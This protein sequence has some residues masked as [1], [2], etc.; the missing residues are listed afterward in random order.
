MARFVVHLETRQNLFDF[1][2]RHFA[3]CRRERL[4]IQLEPKKRFW[5]LY[6]SIPKNSTIEI[7][8][9][10]RI[11]SNVPFTF[12]QCSNNSFFD[13]PMASLEIKDKN[14]QILK[15]SNSTNSEISRFDKFMIKIIFLKHPDMYT[16]NG[17][18]ILS[19]NFRKRCF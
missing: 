6:K 2:M 13:E 8:F 17:K 16:L 7:D 12:V 4:M 5:N 1:R 18:N 15:I 10:L 19:C 3:S 14:K 11:H 9:G